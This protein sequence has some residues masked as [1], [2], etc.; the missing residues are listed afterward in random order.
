MIDE[1]KIMQL[2]G[3]TDLFIKVPY[4]IKGM[5]LGFLGS[6]ISFLILLCIYKF[7]IYLIYPYYEMPIIPIEHLIVINLVL[8]PIFGL[9]GSTSALSSY[10]K[11]K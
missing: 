4:L 10:V 9:I 6:V 7:S 11:N 5:L 3:A 8:G 2:L 1:I